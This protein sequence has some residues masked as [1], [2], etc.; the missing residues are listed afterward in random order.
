MHTAE[1][2]L[3]EFAGLELELNGHPLA[4]P[5]HQACRDEQ[6]CRLDKP[7]TWIR[8][9]KL[10][11][12][13]APMHR[14]IL[15]ELEEEGYIEC[16][17]GVCRSII[18]DLASR[19]LEASKGV[20]Y[21]VAKIPVVDL[22]DECI[23]VCSDSRL[24]RLLCRLLEGY[25]GRVEEALSSMGRCGLRAAEAVLLASTLKA[26]REGIDA[27]LTPPP[28][29]RLDT[30]IAIL[31]HVYSEDTLIL[32]CNGSVRG[33]LGVDVYDPASLAEELL[34]GGGAARGKRLLL[35]TGSEALDGWGLRHVAALVSIARRVAGGR[36]RVVV[37]GNYLYGGLDA[38][39]TICGGGVRSVADG[40]EAL[41]SNWRRM[42]MVFIHMPWGAREEGFRELKRIFG[43]WD[44]LVALE[45][46][47]RLN[48]VAALM[49]EGALGVLRSTAVFI[50]LID[51]VDYRL[52]RGVVEELHGR[53]RGYRGAYLSCIT[54]YRKH[55]YPCKVP[56]SMVSR[57]I[58]MLAENANYSSL[59][60]AG[61]ILKLYLAVNE[62]AVDGVEECLE[63][64]GSGIVQVVWSILRQQYTAA[65]WGGV[66]QGREHSWDASSPEVAGL[67]GGKDSVHGMAE[68]LCIRC[69]DQHRAGSDRVL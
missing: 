14:R 53:G 64:G 31:A 44:M 68:P 39:S 30:V 32:D 41:T 23:S 49:G 56:A 22:D 9:N 67:L 52:Y 48:R 25:R 16:R 45:G 58:K 21:Y 28:G 36:M 10:H 13:R 29:V 42:I 3:G 1:L 66:P 50:P 38:A 35:V 57:T 18:A 15:R 7:P 47:Q 19:A 4:G 12:L 33:R 61:C 24:G 60:Y 65:A 5:E 26:I 20:E 69:P 17:D 62:Y 63:P 59:D 37:A 6:L 43:E 46:V 34:S 2:V 11:S 40:V 27:A 51:A 55:H 54:S 8:L